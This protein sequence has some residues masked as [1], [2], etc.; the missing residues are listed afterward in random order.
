MAHLC[1]THNSIHRPSCCERKLSPQWP[2]Y[3]HLAEG[4]ETTAKPPLCWHVTVGP[5]KLYCSYFF[6]SNA[7]HKTWTAVLPFAACRFRCEEQPVLCGKFATPRKE[8]CLSYP[9][10]RCYEKCSTRLEGRLGRAAT[11][12]SGRT[13]HALNARAAVCN[14]GVCRAWPALDRGWCPS[15]G[16][17]G[18]VANPE[19]S[20]SSRGFLGRVD[21]CRFRG[22]PCELLACQ[23][24]KQTGW[25]GAMACTLSCRRDGHNG[26]PL[27]RDG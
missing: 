23:S 17:H 21:D 2:R 20:L 7:E 14:K 11:E 19:V 3:S 8:R 6:D 5:A 15:G 9:R 13:W 18:L 1:P 16:R 24:G 27:Y 22:Q 12:I 25:P 26:R 4:F 10:I